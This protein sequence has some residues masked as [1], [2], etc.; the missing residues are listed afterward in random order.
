MVLVSSYY[1]K[2]NSHKIRYYTSMLYIP[3][4][5]LFVSAGVLLYF[6]RILLNEQRYR[7][8]LTSYMKKYGVDVTKIPSSEFLPDPM[9][10]H[11]VQGKIAGY[12]FIGLA[13]VLIIAGIYIFQLIPTT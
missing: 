9:K 4:I 13:I 6:S 3:V 1:V 8:F 2:A 5:I 11:L 12:L 10:P 7:S